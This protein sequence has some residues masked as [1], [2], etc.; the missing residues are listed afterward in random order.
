MPTPS[1]EAQL[2][3]VCDEVAY[4]NHDLDDGLRSGLLTLK[5]LEEVRLWRRARESVE[6]RMG[7]LPERVLRAQTIVTLINHLVTDL[8][9]ASADRLAAAGL[10]SAA[11]G[12]AQPSPLVGFSESIE[13]DKAELKNFLYVN[14]YVH[15]RVIEMSER[16]QRVLTGLFRVYRHDPRKLPA[17]VVARFDQEGEARAVSDYVAGMTDRFAM[18]EHR[19]L[20]GPDESL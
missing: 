8:I 18:A 20:V 16:G 19:R 6:D 5:M 9:E 3:D 15:P 12:R 1:I 7:S 13:A 17:H 2:S 14:L 11:A 10:A 4:T